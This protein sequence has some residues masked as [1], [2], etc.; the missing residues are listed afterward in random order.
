M[1][2]LNH[3]TIALELEL[4]PNGE[5]WAWTLTD[6]DTGELVGKGVALEQ[7]AARRRAERARAEY[8]AGPGLTTRRAGPRGEA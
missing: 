6:A 3:A 4:G 7:Q 5:R 8:G 2:F 1:P